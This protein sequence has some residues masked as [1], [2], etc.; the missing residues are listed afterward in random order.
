MFGKHEDLSLIP[1]SHIKMPGMVA[2][3]VNPRTREAEADRSVGLT[4]LANVV[5]SRL[6]RDPTPEDDA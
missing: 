3:T 1:R 4:G 2:C 5:S 6:V